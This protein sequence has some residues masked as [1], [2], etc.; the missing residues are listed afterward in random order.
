LRPRLIALVI[1]LPLLL[2]AFCGWFIADDPL[3]QLQ[4]WGFGNSVSV[5]QVADVVIKACLLTAAL[6]P[7]GAAVVVALRRARRQTAGAAAGNVIAAVIVVAGPAAAFFGHARHPDA[8]NPAPYLLA[9][10]FGTLVGI[11]ILAN[12]AARAPSDHRTARLAV[13]P[14]AILGIVALATFVALIAYTTD[15]AINGV[16]MIGQDLVAQVFPIDALPSVHTDWLPALIF[17]LVASLAALCSAAYA[18]VGV[19]RSAQVKAA[20]A[21]DIVIELDIASS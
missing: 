5:W 11:A 1:A 9:L 2:I 13:L 3:V 21:V 17:S 12:A 8:P 6:A 14:A 20:P 16:P 18:L 10:V 7:I 15:L 19:I 4:D